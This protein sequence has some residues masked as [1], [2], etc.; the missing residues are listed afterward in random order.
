M[1]WNQ[2]L[3]LVLG[4]GA[5]ANHGGSAEPQAS[6]MGRVGWFWRR[7]VN[8][9]PALDEARSDFLEALQ[10]IDCREA[11]CLSMRIRYAPSMR[12]LWHF[13]SDVFLLVSLH[14]NQSEAHTRLETLNQHFPTRSPRSGFGTLLD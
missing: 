11:A 3:R 6:E 13:R 7:R 2:L 10:D 12:A 4:P 8:D 14:R 9:Y 1:K 5:L